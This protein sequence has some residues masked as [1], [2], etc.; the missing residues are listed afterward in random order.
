M[1]ESMSFSKAPGRAMK[2]KAGLTKRN[3]KPSN[4]W[5]KEGS[6]DPG[7]CGASSPEA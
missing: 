1:L 7:G 3:K 6:C 2:A 5:K 4:T